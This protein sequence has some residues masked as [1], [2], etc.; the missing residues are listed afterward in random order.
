ML[1]WFQ[2]NPVLEKR[3]G[4]PPPRLRLV[5]APV[6]YENRPV[7]CRGGALC[8]NMRWFT[9]RIAPTPAPPAA[10]VLDDPKK[11]RTGKPRP[12]SRRAA[13]NT[14]IFSSA[15]WSL[16]SVGGFA[17]QVILFEAD[18]GVLDLAVELGE[19]VSHVGV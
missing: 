6:C 3:P 2:K 16:N 9:A 5:R 4:F 14:S 10:L 8:Q 17:L 18:L 13:S 15:G 19:G 12:S 11:K 1:G 7:P